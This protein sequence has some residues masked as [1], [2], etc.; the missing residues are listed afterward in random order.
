MFSGQMYPRQVPM[1]IVQTV[2]VTRENMLL[3]GSVVAMV[4]V[5]GIRAGKSLDP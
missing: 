1:T 5:M 3:V 2:A 4:M